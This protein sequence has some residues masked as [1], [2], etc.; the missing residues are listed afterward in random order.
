MV[1]SPYLRYEA[2][3]DEL[4]IAGVFVKGYATG[5][6]EHFDLP[7]G[8]AFLETLQEYLDTNRHALL[9]AGPE[10][11]EAMEAK[12][13]RAEIKGKRTPLKGDLPAT[14]EDFLVAMAALGECL[15]YALE[16]NKQ[17]M[18]AQVRLFKLLKFL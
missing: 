18:L 7:D 12:R 15:R 16:D 17:G 1:F 13:K 2:L 3:Q 14:D 11:E 9:P 10:K 8:R 4:V 5:H 6:W